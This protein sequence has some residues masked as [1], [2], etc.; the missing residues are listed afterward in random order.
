M[1]RAIRSF[2]IVCV[3]A[4]VVVATAS[5]DWGG[6]D[7]PN[8][9]PLGILPSS[10][11]TA[12]TGKE[13]ID[14]GVHYLNKARAK[15]GLPAYKLPENFASLSP[16]RQ[17]FILTNLDRIA[18]HV[19]PI[20]GLTARLNHDALASGVW[21]A[22]DP[23]L[24]NSSG[25]T[26]WWPGWAGAFYNAP[27]AYEAW[28]WNDGLGAQ[29]PRCTPSDHSRCWGHRHSILWKYGSNAAMGAAAGRDSSHH[30]RGYAYL[31]VGGS[32]GYSPTYIYTWREAVEAGAGTND[33]DPG[34]PPARMCQV[35]AAIGLKLPGAKRAI[36]KAHCTVG[37]VIHKHTDYVPGIVIRQSPSPGKTYAPGRQVA[38]TVSLGPSS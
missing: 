34:L 18:Y 29:N 9:T 19:A 32:S 38:V 33:Y 37:T 36:E 12:P 26:V 24:S 35:P 17:I 1:L 16:V 6:K 10:C 5:A 25:V 4:L 30:A 14:A 31:F 23:H 13:C 7:P 28:V 15:V 3:L 20:P 27:M 21:V 2:S 11:H 8:N 22:D